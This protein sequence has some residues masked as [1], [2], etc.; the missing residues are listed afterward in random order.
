MVSGEYFQEQVASIKPISELSDTKLAEWKRHLRET[1]PPMRFDPREFCGA[2]YYERGFLSCV[3]AGAKMPAS[4]TADCFRIPWN[5]AIFEALR[6]LDGLGMSGASA[7][8]VYLR[9]S[10]NLGSAGGEEYIQRVAAM[11]GIRSAEPYFRKQ[12]LRLRLGAPL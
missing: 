9:E 11:V 5:R 2:A 8:T 12:L 4:I 6:I 3:I 1:V 7:L 10:G